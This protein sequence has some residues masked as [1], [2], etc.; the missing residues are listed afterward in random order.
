MFDAFVFSSQDTVVLKIDRDEDPVQIF[1][2]GNTYAGSLDMAWKSSKERYNLIDIQYIDKDKNYALDSLS[3]PNDAALAVEPLRRSSVRC[4][5][6]KQSYA[7]RAGRRAL[8]VA[9]H[10]KR[11]FSFKAG[12][13]AIACS[14]G[15]IIGF[16]HDTP[17]IGESGRIVSGSTDTSIKLDRQVTIGSGTY[18]IIVSMPD[19]TL[20]ERTVTN[21]PGQTDTITVSVAFSEA[22]AAYSLYALGPNQIHYKKLRIFGLHL[23]NEFDVSVLCSEVN[24]GVYDYTAVDIPDTNYSLL[25]RDIPDV[26][27]L[28]LSEMV[29]KAND[30]TIINTIEVWFRKPLSASYHI[31]QYKSAKIYL[32][33]DDGLSWRHVGSTASAAVVINDAIETGRTYKVAVVSVSDDALENAIADSP[34][35]SITIIGKAAKPSNVT[36]FDVQQQGNNLHFSWTPIRD[37]DLARYIVKRGTDWISGQLVAEQIDVTEFS[38]PIGIVGDQTYM[39]KAVDTSENESE[40]AAMDSLFVNPPPDG[41]YVMQIDPWAQNREYKLTGVDRIQDN[42]Y[43][44]YYTRDVFVLKT[45]TAWSGLD[46]QN[47]DGLNLAGYTVVSPGEIEQTIPIDLGVAFEFNLISDMLYKNVAGGSIEVQVSYSTDGTT[48]T[49]FAAISSIAKYKARYLKF[50]YIIA[51][52]NTANPIYFYAGTIYV[53]VSEAKK[54]Q[55][56]DVLVDIAGTHITFT[57]EFLSKPRFDGGGIINGVYGFVVLDNMDENGV[58]VFVINASGVAIGGAEVDLKFVGV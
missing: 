24:P 9:R 28:V 10:I 3:I 53:N 49:A 25:S 14:P 47:W 23:D 31:N 58:D 38:V 56:N 6:T 40:V 4:Y 46:G 2:M 50:K 48:F 57:Q 12:I 18:K 36:G 11:L 5:T 42:L 43:S 41:I 26:L 15:D 45:S 7:L 39:I 1:G 22:P 29:A 37:G 17:A 20:E 19:D 51:T 32:S 33:E 35:A 55:F 44:P 8:N 52:S 54:D 21:S 13:D 27:D 16:S 34:Q 30:G